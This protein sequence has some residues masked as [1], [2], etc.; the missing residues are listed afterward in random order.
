MEIEYGKLD[1]GEMG[2]FNPGTTKSGV[3]YKGTF[4]EFRTLEYNNL[5]LIEGKKEENKET[6]LAIVADIETENID[7]ITNKN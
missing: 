2:E 7:N 1:F 4:F 5:M 6:L 3:V